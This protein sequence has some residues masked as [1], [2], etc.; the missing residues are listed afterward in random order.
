M[1]VLYFGAIYD[2]SETYLV[3]IKCELV[4]DYILSSSMTLAQSCKR[5]L[6]DTVMQAVLI[7]EFLTTTSYNLLQIAVH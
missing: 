1:A 6:C 4:N 3:E 2:C 7:V 5:A